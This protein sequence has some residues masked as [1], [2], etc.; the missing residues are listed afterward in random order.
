MGILAMEIRLWDSFNVERVLQVNLRCLRSVL[1]GGFYIDATHDET[2][3]C[4]HS[5]CCECP[6]L[7]FEQTI[8]PLF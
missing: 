2:P 6:R 8:Y 4:D 1:Y 5:L 3:F 7:C